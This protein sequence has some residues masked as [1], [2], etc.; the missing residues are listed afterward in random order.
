VVVLGYTSTLD[1]GVWQIYFLDAGFIAV[2]AVKKLCVY[3]SNSKKQ[4][5]FVEEACQ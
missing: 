5:N 4:R 3:D 2:Y 1:L